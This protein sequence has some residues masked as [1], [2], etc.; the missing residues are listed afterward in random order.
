M[1]VESPVLIVNDEQQSIP[2][3]RTGN[4][5]LNDSL[6]QLLPVRHVA[7]GL[8]AIAPRRKIYKMGINKRNA[9]QASGSS[10]SVESILLIFKIH[11]MFVVKR[12]P[13]IESQCANAILKIPPRDRCSQFRIHGAVQ[14]VKNRFG[15]YR[16][17]RAC[18]VELPE[19]AGI[20]IRSTRQL[21]EAGG[22]CTP[23][24]TREPTRPNRKISCESIVNRNPSP[25]VSSPYFARTFI[26]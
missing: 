12:I 18:V 16:P 15:K 9:R 7:W 5:R 4:N 21:I 14:V 6:S 2:P 19:S 17:F 1:V 23:R 13:L 22:G 3:R 24:V 10:T 26:A 20:E 8:I 11:D 25:P